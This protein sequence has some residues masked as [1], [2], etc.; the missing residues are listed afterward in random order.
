M[1]CD[2]LFFWSTK[3]VKSLSA[4]SG[5]CIRHFHT[6]VYFQLCMSRMLFAA[7]YLWNIICVYFFCFM[8]VTW[9]ALG[10]WKGRKNPSNDHSVCLKCLFS[11]KQPKLS[12]KCVQF[13]IISLLILKENIKSASNETTK[14]QV[15]LLNFFRYIF[16]QVCSQL[17]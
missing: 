11:G 8:Q 5:N 4:C 6:R 10:Q 13:Q 17:A 3:Y 16:L 7:Y 2:A 1:N 12:L 14:M 15:K 9:W